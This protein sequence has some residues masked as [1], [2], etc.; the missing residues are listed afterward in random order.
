MDL[1]GGERNED[2]QKPPVLVIEQLDV[3]YQVAPQATKEKLEQRRA[4]RQLGQLPG[5]NIVRSVG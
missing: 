4:E 2:T 1:V 5:T 3:V